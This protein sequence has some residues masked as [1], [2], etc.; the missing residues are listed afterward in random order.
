MKGFHIFSWVLFKWRLTGKSKGEI[1]FS[2]QKLISE[3]NFI[4]KI[5][6]RVSRFELDLGGSATK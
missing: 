3:S 5:S 4:P 1:F 2:Q 6:E